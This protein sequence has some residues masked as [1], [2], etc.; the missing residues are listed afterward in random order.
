MINIRIEGSEKRVYIDV[1]GYIGINE[2]K[3]FLNEYSKLIKQIKSSNYNLIIK[4]SSFEC[5]RKEDIR[6]ICM[7]FLKTGFKNM[8]IVD[9]NNYIMSN[10][11]LGPIERKIFKK[12]VKVV[13]SINDIR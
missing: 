3:K 7:S 6:T 2:S 4:L 11:S 1:N 9:S 12:S 10:M 5:E 8:Y 13:S